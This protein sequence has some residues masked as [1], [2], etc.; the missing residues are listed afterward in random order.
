MVLIPKFKDVC[1]FEK[2]NKVAIKVLGWDSDAEEVTHLRGAEVK[3]PLAIT[4]FLY[5]GHYFVVKNMSCLVSR[6]LVDNTT[7]FCD[8]CCFRHREKE[9]VEEHQKLC[10]TDDITLKDMPKPGERVRFKNYEWTIEQPFVVIADF[11]SCLTPIDIRK[12]KGTIQY[13]EHKP[14]GYAYQL[15]SRVDPKD[16]KLVPYTA[17]SDDEDVAEHFFNSL[18]ET[19]RELYSKYG[20]PKPMIITDQQQREFDL[21]ERCWICGGKGWDE[22]ELKKVRNHCHYTGTYREAAHSTLS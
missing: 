3:Y 19:T 15:I 1:V 2:K 20:E 11:E 13:Q 6:Q 5:E 16:N 10:K 14:S 12:G 8:Y 21:A 4:P 18:E 9:K 7:Y 17:Q 22:E